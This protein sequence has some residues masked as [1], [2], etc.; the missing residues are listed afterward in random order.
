MIN[1]LYVFIGVKNS[2]IGVKY[3]LIIIIRS[4]LLFIETFCQGIDDLNFRNK[5]G[6]DAGIILTLRQ[7]FI[8][9]CFIIPLCFS[10]FSSASAHSS[11]DD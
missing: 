2:F 8:R 4:I 7:D 1:Y 5:E 6:F 10:S 9:S 11:V 3:L